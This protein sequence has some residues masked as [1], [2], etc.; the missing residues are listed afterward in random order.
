MARS[1]VRG[2]ARLRRV[3]KSLPEASREELADTMNVIAFRLL[4]QAKAEVPVRTGRLRGLLSAKVLVKSLTIKLG[5]VGK[6]QARQGF[7]GF[8]LD[9][10][11]KAQTVKV[12]R[13]NKQTGTVSTYALRVRAIPRERYNFV[14]GRLRDFRKND[15]PRLRDALDRVLSRAARGGIDD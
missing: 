11:R 1:K 9:Q 3:L 6:R 7:Y 5:L 2:A 8:I 12:K 15:L 13:R 10:G 4:G 14:F